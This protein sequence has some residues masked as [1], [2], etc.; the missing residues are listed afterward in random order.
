MQISAK[1]NNHQTLPL[2]PD[3]AKVKEATPTHSAKDVAKIREIAQDFEAIFTE[4]MLKAM[5]QSVPKSEF[6]DGGN[7]EE[8]YRSMLDSEYSKIMAA[9]RNSGIAHALE[10]YMLNA[11]SAQRQGSQALQQ[12]GKQEIIN[13]QVQP[14][15]SF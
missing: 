15:P 13:V 14:K 5:R 1:N 11:G 10:Q 8:I 4:L 9:Q 2:Q 12:V 7:A 3:T 6:I